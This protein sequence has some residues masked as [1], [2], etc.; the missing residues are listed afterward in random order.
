MRINFLLI[1]IFL[2][3]IS[4]AISQNKIEV[5]SSEDFKPI[6]SA[7]VKLKCLEGIC[8]DSLKLLRTSSKGIVINPFK[9]RTKVTISYIGY[10]THLDTLDKNTSKTITLEVQPISLH[11][12]VTTGQYVPQSAQ[13][14][15]FPVKVITEEKIQ[16]QAATNLRD[17]F[18]NEMSIKVSQ[19]N[20][21]GAGM[22]INGISG[23]NVKIMVDGVPVIGRLNGNIDIS[24]INLNNVERVEII[25][26]P[27]STVYGSDA[28]GGVINI[29]TKTKF[30]DK[31][32]VKSNSFY[33]SV[34]TYNFDGDIAVRL[35]E[36]DKLNITGGRNY[37]NGFSPID[38][39][40]SKL[41]KPKEQYFTSLNF[42]HRFDKAVIRY[43]FDYFYEYILS[44][45]NPREPYF[46]TAFDDHF[47]T[48]RMKNSL[49]YQGEISNNKF[50]DVTLAYSNFKRRKNTFLRDLTNLQDILTNSEND[51]DTST[52]DNI[53]FR[54]TYSSDGYLPNLSY[55]SGFEFNFDNASGARISN[56]K[57]NV[58]D[59]A[60]FTSIQYIPFEKFTIQPA[61]R[62]ISNTLYKAPLIPSLNLKYEFTDKLKVRAAYSKGFRAPSLKELYFLFVDVNHNIQGNQNL[63]AE[64]SDSYNLVMSYMIQRDA[65]VYKIEPKIFYN[66]IQNQ[67][68]LATVS[69]SLY[70][71]IN[72][73]NFK[74]LGAELKVQY[75]ID[76]MMINFGYSYLGRKNTLDNNIE[77]PNLKF[78]SEITAGLIYDI[79]QIESKLSIFYKYSGKQPGYS[80]DANKNVTEY[81]INDYSMIDASLSRNFFD[82]YLNLSIG[83]KN[84][85]N[86]T[87]V[88]NTGSLNQGAHSS[89]TGS[90]PFAYGRTFFSTVKINL[91]DGIL[92]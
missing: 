48:F 64:N 24:Q 22:S 66:D 14:S 67:I 32:R 20:I 39:S 59:Y 92:D 27:M 82:K 50:L 81:N 62:V 9:E 70:S 58:Q 18:T 35:S 40:R 36:E 11:D 91:N 51:Q 41:W 89:D 44:R 8:K 1:L 76:G 74:S 55:Q 78:T 68:T 21:L 86:V 42:S 88:T 19:D 15:V 2:L 87:N 61:F 17:L 85:F 63:K 72:L 29:I 71:Y 30:D 90:F 52:F 77:S 57:T 80:L 6:I 46:E 5:I 83:V 75:I 47:K 12:I 33:E 60:F 13:A 65:S 56:A 53:L 69:S 45:G 49:S 54:T 23:Q 16:G 3:N 7:N 26:G 43:N 79:K 10:K 34:G 37:F 28:L 84:L 31:W 73:G 38:T 25:E 4:D